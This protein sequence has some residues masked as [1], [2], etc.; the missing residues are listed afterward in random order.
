MTIVLR[1]LQLKAT[2]SSAAAVP[3]ESPR[4]LFVWWFSDDGDRRIRRHGGHHATDNHEANA[5]RDR[6][7]HGHPIACGNI[8]ARVFGL[9]ALVFR[10]SFS[11]S[12]GVMLVIRR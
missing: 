2:P 5:D 10:Y 8:I 1:D 9:G 11:E 3:T 6:A 4:G 7:Q 12:H